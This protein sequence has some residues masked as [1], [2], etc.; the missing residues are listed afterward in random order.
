MSPRPS[1]PT[2]VLTLLQTP[3][4]VPERPPG[5]RQLEPAGRHGALGEAEGPGH[6]PAA[7]HHGRHPDQLLRG[8]KARID[9]RGGSFPRRA[10]VRG[11][12]VPGMGFELDVGFAVVYG[13]PSAEWQESQS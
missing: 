3:L 1:H 4:P 11:S 6:L 12:S 9:W 5:V 8:G 13:V 7:R 2:P 10:G